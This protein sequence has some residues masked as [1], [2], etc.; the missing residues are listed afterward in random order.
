VVRYL[1]FGERGGD[2]G[3]GRTIGWAELRRLTPVLFA[4]AQAGDQVA[5]RVV[6]RQAEEICVMALTA[7][8]R[9][10]AAGC[11]AARVVDAPWSPGRR[12]S[13]WTS[14]GRQRRQ[15]RHEPRSAP[16]PSLP[17]PPSGSG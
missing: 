4:A 11:G 2:R 8:R 7:L 13:G 12:C 17:H 15:A 6:E 3:A 1:S 16:F 5:A 9:L 10:A 14:C